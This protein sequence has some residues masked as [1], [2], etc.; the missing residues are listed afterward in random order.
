M[1]FQSIGIFLLSGTALLSYFFYEKRNLE[2]EK[3]KKTK[4]VESFGKPKVGGPFSLVDQNGLPVTD[5]DYRGKFML[6][7]F[8][9]TVTEIV[10]NLDYQFCPDVCPEELDKMAE[11]YDTVGM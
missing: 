8:G 3:E 10:F 1:S 5:Q 9:Y 7:Y 11:I 2:L 6:I 4:A